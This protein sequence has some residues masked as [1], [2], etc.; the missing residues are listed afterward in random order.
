MLQDPESMHG[1]FVLPLHGFHSAVQAN[2]QWNIAAELADDPMDSA[3]ARALRGGIKGV[4]MVLDQEVQPLT[5]A[6]TALRVSTQVDVT[7]P[8]WVPSLHA[9]GS[10]LFVLNSDKVLVKLQT[11]LLF[12]MKCGVAEGNLLAP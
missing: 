8:V 1:W 6:S 7:V 10:M 2:N 11:A 4:A 5:R 12:L 3:F 9:L